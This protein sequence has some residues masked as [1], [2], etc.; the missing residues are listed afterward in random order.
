M[1]TDI[2]I[3]GTNIKIDAQSKID[4]KAGTDANIEATANVKVKALANLNTEAG[5]INTIEGPLVK[6]NKN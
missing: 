2:E 4:I 5:T 3:K 6:I 1:S